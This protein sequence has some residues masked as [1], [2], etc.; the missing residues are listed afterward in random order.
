[1]TDND[2]NTANPTQF[3]D[4][5]WETASQE[6]NHFQAARLAA[7]IEGFSVIPRDS[8]QNDF[9]IC[10]LGCGAGWL[11]NELRKFGRVTGV[12]FSPKGIELARTR[13]PD[14]T[15]I[16]SDALEFRPTKLFDVVVSSEV[17]EHIPD[18]ER[19]VQT[20]S[21]ILKPGGYVILT[22]PNARAKK[23]FAKTGNV[24]QPIELWLS[25]SQLLSIFRRDF[26]VILH[27]TFLFD[28]GYSGL[29]RWTSA[30]K[31]LK[32]V[33]STRSDKI[34]DEIRKKMSLGLNHLLV[35]QKNYS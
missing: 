28:F 2:R 16:C 6:L 26:N 11:T 20:I 22:C 14:V 7:I 30:P 27:E 19:Y 24:N 35:A 18:Q 34:Y 3:Y 31:F 12:D 8:G 4:N 32:L 5:R 1:M 9:N 10:D 15:F 25:R 21:Q 13:W 17:I 23:A 33:R 29:Y